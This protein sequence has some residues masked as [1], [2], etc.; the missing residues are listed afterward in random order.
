MAKP[1]E[2]YDGDSKATSENGGYKNT[3]KPNTDNWL[4]L[5]K[6]KQLVNV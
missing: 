5:Q 2:A 3:F 4:F 1:L 6:C